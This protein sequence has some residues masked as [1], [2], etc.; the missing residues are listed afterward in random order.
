MGLRPTR[1]GMKMVNLRRNCPCSAASKNSTQMLPNF[2]FQKQRRLGRIAAGRVRV[3]RS[4]HKT[5]PAHFLFH[6]E[7]S[8]T[9][10][11]RAG[12]PIRPGIGSTEGAV[13]LSLAGALSRFLFGADIRYPSLR[14][15][16]VWSHLTL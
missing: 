5:Q 14:I 13:V 6:S 3:L 15:A 9:F 2:L 10:F 4:H 7:R 16:A 1:A 8:V 12:L 11:R